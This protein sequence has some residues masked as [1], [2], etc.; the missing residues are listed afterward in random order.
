MKIHCATSGPSAC[1]Y[2]ALTQVIQLTDDQWEEVSTVDEADITFVINDRN[3]LMSIYREDKVFAFFSMEKQSGLPENVI[4]LA[5]DLR[6]NI[7]ALLAAKA[8]V[9]KMQAKPKAE[10][11]P[12]P[13]VP[14]DL[15]ETTGTYKVLVIDDLLENLEFARA[16]LDGRHEVTLAHGF[17]EGMRVIGEKKFDAVLCDMHMPPNK[18]YPSYNMDNAPI[19]STLPYGF[20]SV[21]EVTAKGMPIVIVTDGNHHSDWVSAGL[22]HLKEATVNG[23]KVRFFNNLGKRWDKAL[24]SLMEG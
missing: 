14:K 20:F 13:E 23:Q 8:A 5:L 6:G 12:A 21:F 19:G 2:R 16:V 1:V 4:L 22:D 15:V 9:E 3:T 24:K 11:T 18:H 10:L 17:V 7:D